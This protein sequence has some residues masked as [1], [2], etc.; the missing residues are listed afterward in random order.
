MSSK[1]F[2][3]HNWDMLLAYS[4]QRPG[5][6]LNSTQRTAHGAQDRPCNKE[7]SDLESSQYQVEKP[8]FVSWQRPWVSLSNGLKGLQKVSNK[9]GT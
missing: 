7:P 4:E 2:G 9:G 8:C 6:L 3:Y 1:I 5:M